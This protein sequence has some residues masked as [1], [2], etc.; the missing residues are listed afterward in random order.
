M[1]DVVAL[2]TDVLDLDKYWIVSFGSSGA[3]L[4]S[5]RTAWSTNVI[6]WQYALA[7]LGRSVAV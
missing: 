7:A 1:D 6:E 4:N 3:E 2:S 5:P